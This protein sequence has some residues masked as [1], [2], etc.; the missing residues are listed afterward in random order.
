MERK[1]NLQNKQ[2][3][4][5]FLTKIKNK[6]YSQIDIKLMNSHIKNLNYLV[7]KNI[8]KKDAVYVNS[9]TLWEI[10]QPQGKSGKHHYHALTEED[11][12]N[13]LS[14]IANP[15][16]VFKSYS[17]RYAIVSISFSHFNEKTI[18]IIEINADLIGVK[19]A[20]VYKIVTIYPKSKIDTILRNLNPKDILFIK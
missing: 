2:L 3:T 8:F 11:I 13:A 14:N 17:D 18:T 9:S 19:N 6:Q 16:C 7:G 15:Y 12:F 10:M 5:E 20:K 1:I 4:I